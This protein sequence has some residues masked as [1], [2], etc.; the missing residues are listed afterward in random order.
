ME[1]LSKILVDSSAGYSLI[2][3][4]ILEYSTNYNWER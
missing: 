4:E 3:S 1:T 2:I